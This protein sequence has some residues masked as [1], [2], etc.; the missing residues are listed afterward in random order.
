MML[1]R[2]VIDLLKHT[3]STC[4]V[5]CLVFVVVNG[6]LMLICWCTWM[7]HILSFID[8]SDDVLLEAYLLENLMH[9][10]GIWMGYILGHV[11]G[12]LMR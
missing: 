12:E 4:V 8:I 9:A 5:G 2:D 6:G 1:A 7:V 11:I 10:F 3:T